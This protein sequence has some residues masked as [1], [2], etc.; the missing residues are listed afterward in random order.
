MSYLCGDGDLCDFEMYKNRD[1]SIKRTFRSA[2]MR[3]N[4]FN[5]Y[6]DTDF[7]QRFHLSKKSAHNDLELNGPHVKNFTK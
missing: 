2:G 7:I 4:H 5:L 1:K 3:P 6:K